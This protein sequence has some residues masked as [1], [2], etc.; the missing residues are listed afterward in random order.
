MRGPAYTLVG[1]SMLK[2]SLTISVGNPPSRLTGDSG[3][4]YGKM[5]L[6]LGGWGRRGEVRKNVHKGKAKKPCGVGGNYSVMR[7][8]VVIERSITGQAAHPLK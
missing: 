1:R 8:V 2:L 3:I 4:V 6:M 7:C 5:R